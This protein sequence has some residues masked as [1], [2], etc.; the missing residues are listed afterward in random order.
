MAASA[1]RWQVSTQGGSRPRW[2]GDGR[3]L[4]YVSLDD[5]RIIRADVR[6]GAAGFESDPP[7]VFTEI[8]VMPV[9]R[10]PFDVTADGRLLVLER[11]I[12]A[13]APLVLVA[14]WRTVMSGR[15]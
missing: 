15:R 3:A 2:S 10:S 4:F 5:R 8:P 6:T 7:R 9:A 1:P 12:T 13:G 14:N 11:T